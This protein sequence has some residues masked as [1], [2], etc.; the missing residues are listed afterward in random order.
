MGDYLHDGAVRRECST[1]TDQY[2]RQDRR[3]PTDRAGDH[4]THD[5]HFRHLRQLRHTVVRV[6]V[7]QVSQPHELVY[8]CVVQ[9]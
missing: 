6:P 4:T 1:V 3:N 7:G 9:K 5:L 8:E 2:G